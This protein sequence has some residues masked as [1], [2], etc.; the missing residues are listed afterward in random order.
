VT[1]QHGRYLF[2]AMAVWVLYG[3]AGWLW[4][5]GR[6]GNGRVARIAK[7]VGSLTFV[8]LLLFFLLLGAQTYATD[9]TFIEGEMVAVAHWLADNTPPDALIAAHDIGAIGYWAERPLLDLAGLISPE[10][11]PLLADESALSQYILV[12]EADYLVTAPGWP[13]HDLTQNP[14]LQFLYTT[15][16]RWTQE[17]GVNNMSV[18]KLP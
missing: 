7:R 12:S 9:V 3:L 17:Q 15:N 11:I 4:L 5:W 18:Y 13:Y 10:I 1:Y 8:L 6:V 14:N 16:H 2:P